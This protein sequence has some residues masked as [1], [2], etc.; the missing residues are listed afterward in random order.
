LHYIQLKTHALGNTVDNN[1]DGFNISGSSNNTF[2]G[3]TVDN[4]AFNGKTMSAAYD[5][6]HLWSSYN[7]VLAG[8]A[9]DRNGQHGYYD[10][11]TGS[12]TKGTANFYFGDDC[13]GNGLGGSNPT[14]L[15]TPQS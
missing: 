14:G 11:P 7:N 15:C 8:N 4:S 13:S 5:G 6:F 9:A 1:E 12:G 2:T 10:D 3:N